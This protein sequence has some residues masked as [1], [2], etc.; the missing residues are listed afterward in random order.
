MLTQLLK[1]RRFAPLFWC[2]F[3]SALN[4]NFLKNA[5]G[6]LILFGI[7]AEVL[8]ID[9]DKTGYLLALSSM[10]FIAPFFI[11]SALGGQL[12]DKFDKARVAER[13]KLA[14][15]PVA[16]IAAVGFYLQSLPI[17]FIAVA[18]F[19]IIGALFGPVKYGILPEKLATGELAAGNALVEGAT[20]L[21]I[22]L[23][24]IAGSVA[25]THAKS[26]GLIVFIIVALAVVC[27]LCARMIPT[28][29]PA[30]PHLAITF[31]PWRS[32]LSLLRELKADHRLWIG[33]TVT[34][35]FWLAGIVALSLLPVLIKDRMGG[36]ESVVALC[37]GAFTVGIAL[38][39]VLAARASQGRPNLALVPFGAALMGVFALAIGW[40]AWFITPADS[41]L[42]VG[43]FLATGRGLAVI[44]CFIGLAVAGGLYIVPAFA[45]V[46]S[47]APIERRARVV[48]AVNVL[49][50]AYMTCASGIVALLQA[51]GVGVPLLFAGL[52]VGSLAALLIV[53]KAWGHEGVRDFGRLLFQVLLRLEV[54]GIENLANA[55]TNESKT[56]KAPG[57]VI[58]P[59]HVSLLDGPILH[60]VLPGNAAFAVNTEI[61]EAAWVKPFLRVIRA[62]RLDPTRP[63]AARH[64]VNVVKD[65]ETLV[66]FPEGRITTTGSLMKVYD[67]AAMI[68]DKADALVVP[69][70]VEGPERS[71]FG[72]LRKSQIKK[73]WLP[74]VTVTFLAPRRLLV[75]PALKG[76]ARRQAAGLALQ[77]ILVDTAV[78]TAR[79]ERTI[80]D[81][82]AETMA[83]RATKR[84]AIEDP[85]SH[86]LSTKK[87]VL[88]A[89]VLGLKLASL[90]EEGAT[91]GLMLPTSAAAAV[92]FFALQTIGRVPAMIN[93]TAGASNIRAAC[94]AARITTIL[95]SRAFIDR[96]RLTPLLTEIA[97]DVRIIHL[98]D[99]RASIGTIDKLRALCRGTKPWVERNP[100]DAA[101]ILFTSGSEGT[102]KGVVLS[103][104]NIL[105]NIAQ[106]LT[107]VDANG[108]DKVFNA[109]PVFHSFG[110]TAGLLMPLVG[111]IPVYLYPTPLHYRI[112]PELVYNTGATI[113]FGTD[114]FLNGYA[115]AAHPYDF[116]NIRFIMAGA[117]PVKD[118]TRQLYM[119]RFGVRILEGYGVTE[120]APV[121][122]MN[123]LIANKPGSVGRLSPL[124]E[125]RLEPVAGVDPP[126]GREQIGR[127]FVR[128]PNVMLGYYRAERPGVLEPPA[129][130]W[131]DTG[132]I[133]AIDTQGYLAIKGRAKRF[134]KVG[135][136]MVSLSAVEAMVADIWPN[137]VN[138]VVAAPDSRKGERLIL[139]T[140][141]RSITREK[142]LHHARAKGASD[143]MVP[144]EIV[145]VDKVPLL[146]SGKP[147][148]VAASALAL[149]R[150]ATKSGIAAA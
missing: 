44:T 56:N 3:C 124:M 125:A 29:G 141:D 105:A 57:V 17:L 94:T 2:Q 98:E 132:D 21:A 11:L 48:A 128:G 28:F 122:A 1:A 18:M 144:A 81:A 65:G 68:A 115:R 107:R 88:G 119:N 14:E 86:Q 123:T 101:V 51:V 143:L 53:L 104:R 26:A 85:L 35:W 71:S 23:G 45:A 130:G 109:L 58:A 114:T 84:P 96:G 135:G 121:L 63:L 22:L 102:P 78:S 7:N 40:I 146:G 127:L 69:V 12:A 83:T 5:L 9:K 72:Y 111:G 73:S 74:K 31:N 97:K 38:G 60:A 42:E 77:D 76:K 79:F 16:A 140:A 110:L 145:V 116:H 138:V 100:D 118:R 64:L 90:E 150:G 149:A 34:S 10:V 129:G 43:S 87:L 139:L 24:T 59:N 46:Q 25:V 32:T 55:I 103:H 52:G 61:A 13:I 4:D 50:A 133:V 30:A 41:P 62:H 142:L 106:C 39:S 117:E 89:Q 6:M 36:S 82:V 15:I 8:I 92:A 19:G 99:L 80:F 120:T 54:K 37:L 91:I 112:I 27:W 113:L 108:E 126:G 47:W 20:F 33:G 131:H 67:G 136:E 66:I 137:V 148:Y 93:F 75:D 49:N 95:T 147:D 70:R 134:A